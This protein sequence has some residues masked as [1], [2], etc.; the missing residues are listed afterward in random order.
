MLK[1]M[2]SLRKNLMICSL[3]CLFSGILIL[4]YQK[5]F[6]FMSMPGK[7]EKKA[8]LRAQTVKPSACYAGDLVSIPG[9]GRSPEGGHGNVLQCSC[10]ENLHG[11]RSLEG[12]GAWGHKGSDRIEQLSTDWKKLVILKKIVPYS[13]SNDKY[14][15]MK[16]LIEW[17][18][19]NIDKEQW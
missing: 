2:I 18:S 5:Y 15:Q 4:F 10:L 3:G 12:H 17:K 19:E 16:R 9:L 6:L 7:K 13:S 1:A 14:G 8:S 11:Q